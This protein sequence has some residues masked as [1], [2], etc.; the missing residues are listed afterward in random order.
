MEL[1]ILPKDMSEEL[2]NND[3]SEIT[4]DVWDEILKEL[5]ELDQTVQIKEVN[6][7][8][9]ADWILILAVL[10]SIAGVISIGDKLEK[11]IDGWIKIGKR[12]GK[13]FKKSDR[14]YVDVDAA[15]ILAITFISEFLDIN[16]LALV[17]SHI[18][19]LTDF[20]NW[21]KDRKTEDFISKP[22]NI[23]YFTFEVNSEK[24]ITLA[25][26][27]NGEILKLLDVDI[28]EVNSFF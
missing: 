28:E 3:L 16:N 20:S 23:Y 25:V 7:G 24:V 14:L 6:L 10:S 5:N 17:D 26:K 18:T 11:G 8:K 27:S 2:L 9:G 4:S 15:K 19:T 12:L 21:F 22:F 1:I 13:L